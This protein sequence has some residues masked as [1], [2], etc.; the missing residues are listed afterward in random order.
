M[1]WQTKNPERIVFHGE[2]ISTK[3]MQFII[4]LFVAIKF[5]LMIVCLTSISPAKYNND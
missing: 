1:G 4:Y 5:N 2:S 3:I